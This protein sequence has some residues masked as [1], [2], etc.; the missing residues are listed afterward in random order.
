MG[1][2]MVKIDPAGVGASTK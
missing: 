2:E 1:N